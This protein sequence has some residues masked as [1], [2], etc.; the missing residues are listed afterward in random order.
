MVDLAL[1]HRQHQRLAV[2]E[3]AVERAPAHA[4]A[5]G[6]ILQRAE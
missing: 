5:F 4:C 2:L 3:I 1:E 6:H